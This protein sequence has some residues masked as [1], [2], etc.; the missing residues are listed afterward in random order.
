MPGTGLAEGRR[1]RSSWIYGGDGQTLGDISKGMRV[2]Y[3]EIVQPAFDAGISLNGKICFVAIHV[4]RRAVNTSDADAFIPGIT[5]RKRH[6]QIVL[7]GFRSARP[8]VKDRVRRQLVGEVVAIHNMNPVRKRLSKGM[9][10]RPDGLRR[11]RIMIAGNEEDW[12]MLGATFAESLCKLLPEIGL[13]LRII[14]EITGAE[15]CI[16]RV[17]S[18]N[19]KNSRDHVHTRA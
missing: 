19:V 9:A 12:R 16:H 8:R 11:Q 2:A 17:A 7:P 14:E 4:E 10:R 6:R 5:C 3:G 18:R 15:D 1:L 13:W